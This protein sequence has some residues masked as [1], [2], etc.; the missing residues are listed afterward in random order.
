VILAFGPENS[1][2]GAD[3]E[4]TA[5]SAPLFSFEGVAIDGVAR[6]RLD[7]IWLT[8]RPGRITVIVGPSGAGKSTLLRCCN[9]LEVPDRGRLL[10][11]GHDVALL[12]PRAL[13]CSVG[14]VFQR[15]VLFPGTV[16][17]NLLAARQEATEAACAAALE[18][19]ELGTDFLDR[20]VDELSG[21][22]AQR[23]CIARALMLEPSVLL[24]DE[25]TSSLDEAAARQ[26][27]QTVRS[28]IA[29]GRSVLWVTHDRAQAERL[30]DDLVVMDAGRVV[31]GGTG[32]GSAVGRAGED[33]EAPRVDI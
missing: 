16:R 21:G 23:A 33:A 3:A 28:L 19:A 15:P 9:R 29:G 18:A 32:T 6:P 22:E 12:E 11:A 30:A 31:T 4:A 10:Y 17:S 20:S 7:D 8:V 2:A 27:E 1:L 14:M 5:G 26:V 25:P 24:A 13:R